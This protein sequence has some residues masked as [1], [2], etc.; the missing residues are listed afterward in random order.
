MGAEPNTCPQC[1]NAIQ[2]TTVS[3]SFC[4]CFLGADWLRLRHELTNMSMSFTNTEDVNPITQRLFHRSFP[5]LASPSGKIVAGYFPSDG[6]PLFS[7]LHRE[8]EWSI[9]ATPHRNTVL[10]DGE[11]IST[12]PWPLTGMEKLSLFSGAE[13]QVIVEFSIELGR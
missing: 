9:T 6:Q 1:G 2:G 5:R 4:G 13:E 3:C 8:G 11:V 7:F 12:T 10:I